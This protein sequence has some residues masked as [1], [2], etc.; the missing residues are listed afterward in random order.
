MR[1]KRVL[2]ISPSISDMYQDIIAQLEKFD[3]DVDYIEDYTIGYD[4]LYVRGER[5]FI[6]QNPINKW[7]HKKKLANYWRTTLHQSGYNHIYDYLLVIDGQRLSPVLFDIL[8]K[9]NPKL[10]AANYLYDST[11]SLYAFQ[12]NFKYFDIVAS[13]DKR[14]CATYGLKFLP[15]YWVDVDG[16]DA[17]SY[18]IFGFGGFSIGRKHLYEKI[19]EISAELGLN[20]YIK[21]YLQTISNIKKHKRNQK[22][23]KLLGL[24]T[25]IS[26]EDYKSEII[27]HEAIPSNMFQKITC[28]SAITLDT[29]N[30]EQDGMTARFMWALGAGRK[31]ITTNKSYKTYECYNP[32]QVFIVEDAGKI[33]KESLQIFIQA[34]F[35]MS[36]DT[37]KQISAW[38][39]DKWLRTLLSL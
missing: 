5:Q 26:I 12:N 11:V 10:W 7:L 29:V 24:P 20:S 14:D 23:R 28:N 35:Q 34:E 16:S 31:I 13:F 18:D 3:F 36:E 32:D 6:R 21:L 25:H 37:K 27:T 9:R 30:F 1:K 33:D 38:R 22:I 15:I 39:I 17:P 8:R 4:P 19:G 2:L